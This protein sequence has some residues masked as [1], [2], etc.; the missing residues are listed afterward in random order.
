MFVLLAGMVVAS[1]GAEPVDPLR[2]WLAVSTLVL[3]LN[4]TVP[5]SIPLLGA[6]TLAI[7]SLLCAN[8]T[9]ANVSSGLDRDTLFATVDA[10]GIG[11][12]CDGRWSIGDG[13]VRNPPIPAPNTH[14]HTPPPS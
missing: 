9:V 11:L 5:F 7:H 8:I 12:R 6:Q 3:P 1:S 4:I 2:E 10:A 13:L 14:T